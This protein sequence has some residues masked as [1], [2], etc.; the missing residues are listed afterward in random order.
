MVRDGKQISQADRRRSRRW[1]ELREMRHFGRV[2]RLVWPHRKY[3]AVAIVAMFGVA[4][5]YTGTLASLY[6][7]LKVLVEKETIHDFLNRLYAQDR[8][9]LELTTPETEKLLVAEELGP[10]AVQ[11]VKLKEK[12]DLYKQGVRKFEFIIAV[13]GERLGGW[14]L[15]DRLAS[16]PD[17]S[18]VKLEV[19]SAARG[20]SLTAET[21]CRRGDWHLRVLRKLAGYVPREPAQVDQSQRVT[22]RLKMVACM[23]GVVLLIGLVGNFCRFIGQYYGAVVGARTLIDLRRMMYAKAMMMPVSFYHT[24]GVSDTMS[25]FVRD[26]YDVIGALRTLFGKVLREPLKAIGAFSLALYIEPRVTVILAVIVPVAA[27]LFRKFGR[28]IRRANEKLLASYGR[29]LGALESTLTGIKVV[30]AYTMEHRERKR[31]FTVEREMLRHQLRIDMVNAMSSPVIEVLGSAVVSGGVLWIMWMVMRDRLD[32][33]P[34]EFFTL[35]A[36][37]AAVADPVRKLSNIYNSIQ[38]ANAA[39]KRI[40]ELIDTPTEFE[41]RQG[42]LEARGPK[43]HI[44]FRNVSF[45]YPGS[46]HRALSGVD[47]EIPAGSVVAIVGPNGSGKTTLISLLIRFFD[48]EEGAVLWDGIDVR[49]FR[50]RSLRRQISYVSQETVIFADTVRNNIAY[51]NHKAGMDQII[52]AARQAHADE[53]IDRL[54]DGYDTVLGEHG[55][56]LS[57]GECQRLAIARAIL[58]DA[59]VLIFDEATSQIDADSEQKIQDAIDHFMPGRTAIVIA[60]RFSTIGKADKI[61]VMDRGSIVNTGDH[62]ELM[63]ISPLYRSLYETQLRGLSVI[64]G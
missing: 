39:A 40:F 31:Y 44:S 30:K 12:H 34:S 9:G 47:L 21:V 7:G 60:H 14:E 58:H 62:E 43:S 61:V 38:R 32:L 53:F 59:P 3:L 11:I 17:E 55:V 52:H 16:L 63:A 25:R 36:A 8:L 29:L 50:L 49:E 15:L 42:P 18:K 51:G 19:W 54:P 2:L 56:T 46:E 1:R 27:I 20:K 64:D 35:I 28:R 48:P 45:S 10:R 23:L 57:G 33:D 4:I 13:D 37:V 6:P 22:F 26:T 41:L 5:C 24:R